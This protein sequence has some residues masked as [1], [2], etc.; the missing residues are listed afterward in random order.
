MTFFF[1]TNLHI[2]P[3]SP[4]IPIPKTPNL[5]IFYSPTPPVKTKTPLKPEPKFQTLHFLSHSHTPRV[6]AMA[7]AVSNAFHCPKLHFPKGICGPKSQIFHLH[8]SGIYFFSPVF[9]A[10]VKWLIRLSQLVLQSS[11]LFP[12]FLSDQNKLSYWYYQVS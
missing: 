4:R 6:T 12:S 7:S 9:Y 2:L 1:V 11:F 5:F 8:P 10:L 3:T